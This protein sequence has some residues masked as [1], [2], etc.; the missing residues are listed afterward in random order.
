[1]ILAEL[2]EKLENGYH[3]MYLVET[4]LDLAEKKGLPIVPLRRIITDNLFNM[5]SNNKVFRMFSSIS[6][7][8]DINN[9]QIVVPCQTNLELAWNIET[10]RLRALEKK[11]TFKVKYEWK[12]SNSS[13]YPCEL[14]NDK[15]WGFKEWNQYQAIIFPT[16]KLFKSH[17]EGFLIFKEHTDSKVRLYHF[18]P[19]LSHQSE[20]EKA[21]SRLGL[22]SELE[23][24]LVCRENTSTTHIPVF[25]YFREIKQ[26]ELP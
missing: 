3:E 19:D 9:N 10:K 1:M 11:T 24:R 16:E 13:T 6:S 8:I 21:V 22:D 18:E 4:S 26:N 15:V 20:K 2:L 17:N 25:E 14:I 23:I 5:L 12:N 7:S